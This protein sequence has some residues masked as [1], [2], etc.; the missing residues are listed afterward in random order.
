[1]ERKTGSFRDVA[2]I[3]LS[4]AVFLFFTILIGCS[5]SRSNAGE[6]ITEA[7]QPA[8][9]FR[10]VPLDLEAP[11]LRVPMVEEGV[12]RF[13]KGDSFLG[14]LKVLG[15]PSSAAREVVFSFEKRCGLGQISPG[16]EMPYRILEG[17]GLEAFYF[18]CGPFETLHVRFE[19]NR[20]V[21]EIEEIPHQEIERVYIVKVRKNSSLISSAIRVGVSERQVINLARVFRSDID[22]N[23]DI[24]PGDELRIWVKEV[25]DKSGNALALGSALAVL[26][27]LGD[28]Q[29]WGI[30]Y[31]GQEGRGFFDKKGRSLKKNFLKSPLPFLRVTSGFTMRR[32]HPILKKVR[33]HLGVDFGAPIGTPI[34]AAAN[35]KVVYSGWMRGYG[36][37][38][39]IR[40]NPKLLTLYGHMNKIFVKNGQHVKQGKVIGHVGMTGMATGPHLHYGLYRNGKAVDPM[41]VKMNTSA[42]VSSEEFEERRDK[43]VE[44]LTSPIL[45]NAPE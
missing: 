27:V 33:P 39:K 29:Y 26:F 43:A 35:G 12:F 9:T 15:T 1:M 42:V 14:A 41:K 24:H 37:T 36:K 38:V 45:G 44:L 31:D 22:F 4:T 20:P 34:M 30:W 23:N 6:I 16:Q 13:G 11:F 17:R 25:Q 7:P 21:V 32:F 5:C 19:G 28:K 10:A 2:T 18:P 40:H 8:A 3:L